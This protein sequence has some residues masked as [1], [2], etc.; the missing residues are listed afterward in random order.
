MDLECGITEEHVVSVHATNWTGLRTCICTR[1]LVATMHTDREKHSYVT[2]PVMHDQL[3]ESVVS[4]TQ[5]PFFNPKSESNCILHTTGI[6][7]ASQISAVLKLD[8]HA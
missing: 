2:K 3:E 5:F 8:V 1:V 6:A 4:N 7:N